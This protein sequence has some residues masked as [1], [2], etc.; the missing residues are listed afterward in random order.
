MSTSRSEDQKSAFDHD[1]NLYVS[2]EEIKDAF[3]SCKKARDDRSA[4]KMRSDEFGLWREWYFETYS[5]TNPHNI[6][7]K[8][9]REVDTRVLHLAHEILAYVILKFMEACY[10]RGLWIQRRSF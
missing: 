7:A 6:V 2:C 9:G 10:K 8:E 4:V 3:P 5:C 1:F